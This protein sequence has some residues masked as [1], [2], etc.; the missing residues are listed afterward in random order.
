MDLIELER[1]WL[2]FGLGA[3]EGA[4]VQALRGMQ[5]LAESRAEAR[6]PFR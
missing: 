5:G 6:S 3:D 2:H 1:R 4:R